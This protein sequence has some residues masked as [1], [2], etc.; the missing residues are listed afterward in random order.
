MRNSI[1]PYKGNRMKKGKIKFSELKNN[2]G[3]KTDHFRVCDNVKDTKGDWK[4]KA[5]FLEEQHSMEFYFPFKKM[6][7]NLK[8]TYSGYCQL[9][10]G[11]KGSNNDNYFVTSK[12][13]NCPLVAIP[14]GHNGRVYDGCNNELLLTEERLSKWPMVKKRMS[15]YLTPANWAPHEYVVWSTTSEIA[16]ATFSQEYNELSTSIGDNLSLIPLVFRAVGSSG[17]SKS[18]VSYRFFYGS[19]SIANGPLEFINQLDDIKKCRKILNIDAIEKTFEE[20][21]L[22]YEHSDSDD[23]HIVPDGFIEHVDDTSGEVTLVDKVSGEEM[24]MQEDQNFGEILASF[25][26]K[27]QA[28]KIMSLATELNRTQEITAI[29]STA[30]AFSLLNS[31]QNSKNSA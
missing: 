30:A 7:N 18:G 3:V 14:Q 4:V 10:V 6:E 9:P 20:A 28:V 22:L 26:N 11:K 5:G 13:I 1:S 8:I 2:R 17:K 15:V 21:S 31:L 19:I 27:T 16:I 29:N 12:G 24:P 23:E 25:V